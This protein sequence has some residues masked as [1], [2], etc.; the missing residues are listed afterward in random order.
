MLAKQTVNCLSC[1]SPP[2]L[3]SVSYGLRA[4]ISPEAENIESSQVSQ[5]PVGSWK[6]SLGVNLKV[7]FRHCL[8]LM[9]IQLTLVGRERIL[10]WE[11]LTKLAGSSAGESR[12]GLEVVYRLEVFSFVMK[13]EQWQGLILRWAIDVTAKDPVCKVLLWK[14]EG[15][16]LTPSAQ[17]I[18]EWGGLSL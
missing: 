9:W 15:L 14:Q 2:A 7:L 6:I 1:L 11:L 18:P 3:V 17:E 12:V 13:G 5:D 10:P 16:N 8:T 4:E